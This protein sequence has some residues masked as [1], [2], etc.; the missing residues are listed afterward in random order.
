MQGKTETRLGCVRRST[1]PSRKER[2]VRDQIVDWM[3]GDDVAVWKVAPLYEGRR[4]VKMN[5]HARIAG[6]GFPEVDLASE[7]EAD[8]AHLFQYVANPMRSQRNSALR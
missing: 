7:L 8:D 1:W 3:G 4:G 5:N 6:N 2:A